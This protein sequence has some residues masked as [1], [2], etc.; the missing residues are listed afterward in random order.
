MSFAAA[1]AD[2]RAANLIQ[3]GVVTGVG[4]GVARVQIGDLD[5]PDLPVAQLRAGALSFWWMPTIG[6]QVVVACPSGD[7]ARGVVLA[8]IYAGNA[9]SSDLAVPMIDLAGGNMVINGSI[10]VRGSIFVTENVT[11]SGSMT[12]AGDV[13]ASGIS[14]VDHVHG[15]I[16]RGGATTDAPQ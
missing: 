9:P 7:V 11:S 14:L 8:S 3:I 6:E 13:T 1:E 5:T 15:G 10:E 12:V 2:R 4:A 16:L